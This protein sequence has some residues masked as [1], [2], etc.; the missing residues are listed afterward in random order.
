MAKA[1]QK[2]RKSAKRLNPAKFNIIEATA[3]DVNRYIAARSRLVYSF[4][5]IKDKHN[6]SQIQQAEIKNLEIQKCARELE[7][8]TE[9]S[10]FSLLD[11]N[12]HIFFLVK[13]SIDYGF[14]VV[15]FED[16]NTAYISDLT[17]FKHLTGMGTLFYN[18]LENDFRILGITKVHLRAPFDGCKPF[19]RKMGF[20]VEPNSTVHY[21]K[22]L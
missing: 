6:T 14:A 22:F 3:K 10:F 16:S 5:V 13:D 11:Q 1:L 20:T 18:I 9:N 15:D 21:Q 2:N 7:P 4:N 19:W 8:I 12:V 17:V